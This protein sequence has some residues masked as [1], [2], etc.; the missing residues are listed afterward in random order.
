M[1]SGRGFVSAQANT[2]AFSAYPVHYAP[3]PSMLLATPHAA[4]SNFMPYPAGHRPGLSYSQQGPVYQQSVHS[5]SV[6]PYFPSHN[7]V[8]LATPR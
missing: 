6:A 2:T 4:S 7:S 1:N 5:Q 3:M 8:H